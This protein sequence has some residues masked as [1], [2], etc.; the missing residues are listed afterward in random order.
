M[1]KSFLSMSSEAESRNEY[2]KKELK[3]KEDKNR[4]LGTEIDK[5]KVELFAVKEELRLKV[6]S[7]AGIDDENA[8]L[9]N[10][11]A[12]GK[13]LELRIMDFTKEMSVLQEEIEKLK[14]DLAYKQGDLSNKQEEIVRLNSAVKEL[15]DRLWLAGEDKARLDAAKEGAEK[16]EKE[17][18]RQK[19]E[20]DAKN[21]AMNALQVEISA[22][23]EKAAQM[24]GLSERAKGLE[25]RIEDLERKLDEATGE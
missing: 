21:N 23:R 14:V 17:C 5:Q 24:E 20:I 22:L 12:S 25:G 18:I 8:R 11:V 10:E 3:A 2:L 16:L 1:L 6:L 19:G 7:L 15:N 9:K 13:E 4:E